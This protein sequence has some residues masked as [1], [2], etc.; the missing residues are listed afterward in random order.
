MYQ[1][2]PYA[3]E[4]IAYVGKFTRSIVNHQTC[5]DYVVF[6][7]HGLLLDPTIMKG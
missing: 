4:M 6:Y 3:G 1:T 5:A 2:S 7:T